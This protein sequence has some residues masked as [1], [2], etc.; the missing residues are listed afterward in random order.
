MSCVLAEVQL[1]PSWLAPWETPPILLELHFPH[2]LKAVYGHGTELSAGDQDGRSL[3]SLGL[4]GPVGRTAASPPGS[5][6]RRP[7]CRGSI[8]EGKR[9]GPV[10]GRWRGHGSRLPRCPRPS[11]CRQQPL[12]SG[13]AWLDANRRLLSH[14]FTGHMNQAWPISFFFET[15]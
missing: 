5:G 13:T 4:R 10:S 7:E 6:G 3:G 8:E 1:Y 9:A 11:S 12:P 15:L 2:L 14:L